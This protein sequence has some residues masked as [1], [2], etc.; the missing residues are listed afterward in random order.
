MKKISSNL[1]N[2][3]TKLYNYTDN[4]VEKRIVSAT[5]VDI[6]KYPFIVA[7]EVSSSGFWSWLVSWQ[8]CCTGSLINIR[9]VITAKTTIYDDYTYRVVTEL[10][11]YYELAA[12]SAYSVSNIEKHPKD[13]LALI[14]LNSIIEV[15]AKCTTISIPRIPI[16]DR[17]KTATMIGY[18]YIKPNEKVMMYR[19]LRESEVKLKDRYRDC[20]REFRKYKLICIPGATA[21]GEADLGAALIVETLMRG[22]I[23]IGIAS[24]IQ[25]ACDFTVFTKISPL[26][27]WIDDIITTGKATIPPRPP[28]EPPTPPGP[29]PT[30]PPGPPTTEISTRE[31]EET[32]RTDEP[33]DYT[34]DNPRPPTDDP[35]IGKQRKPNNNDFY[36][37]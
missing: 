20:P 10:S 37:Y 13:N 14:R 7:I 34:D 4:M 18:G 2:L 29:S 5:G 25:N 23:L 22:P 27:K 1:T 30:E 28:T 8:I 16:E 11:S 15:S 35:E 32:T 21:C 33:P 24:I 17:H 6:E 19:D 3:N 31:T 36:I 26:V 12:Y 9:W